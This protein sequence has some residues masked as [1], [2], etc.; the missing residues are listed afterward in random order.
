PRAS[1]AAEMVATRVS[2]EVQVTEFVTSWWEPSVSVATAVKATVPAIPV[3]AVAGVTAVDMMR[4]GDTGVVARAN[5]LFTRAVTTAG[6][7]GEW[8][9]VTLPLR[10]TL[11]AL[12]LNVAGVVRSAVVPSEYVPVTISESR[13]PIA[14]VAVGGVIAIPTSVRPPSTL[15][16]TRTSGNPTSGSAS[17]GP[18]S[19]DTSGASRP[20]ASGRAPFTPSPPHFA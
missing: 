11:G 20:E 8:A 14:R 19:T 10:E 7:P 18:T 12:E 9:W 1:P 6:G 3:V 13:V 17:T 4:A 5:R 16:S 2:D 15:A